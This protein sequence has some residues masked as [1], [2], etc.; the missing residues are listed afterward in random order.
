M[1]RADLHEFVDEGR[2][3]TATAKL[4]MHQ[5]AD[6]A[7]VT[8]PAAQLLVQRGVRDDPAVRHRQQW[9]DAPEVDV[10]APVGDHRRVIHAMFDEEPLGGRDGAKEIVK[11]LFVRAFERTKFA[12]R[13]GLQRDLP[14]IVFQRVVEHSG[15]WVCWPSVNSGRRGR[16]APNCERGTCQSSRSASQ[17]NFVTP[18]MATSD[19]GGVASQS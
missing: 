18:G 15:Q 11:G 19:F 14:W 3:E 12:G 6:A 1:S 7:D 8:F 4:R 10:P 2:G 17:T 13:T 9:Q 16:Q 5:H